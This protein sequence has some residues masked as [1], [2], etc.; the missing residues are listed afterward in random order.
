MWR[1]RS[2]G[3]GEARGQQAV[4]IPLLQQCS[5][6]KAFYTEGTKSFTLTGSIGSP[7][8]PGA[9][10]VGD[11]ATVNILDDDDGEFG[12]NHSPA[13]NILA[14]RCTADHKLAANMS[15]MYYRGPQIVT[16]ELCF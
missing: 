14:Y 10:F 16:A 2:I 3:Q 6:H 15:C 7:A 9:V 1:E 8:A 13:A 12:C 4:Q 11:P 5:F